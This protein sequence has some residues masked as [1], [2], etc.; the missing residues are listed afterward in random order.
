MVDADIF[1]HPAVHDLRQCG[2]NY[3]NVDAKRRMHWY[4]KTSTD[5][6][7]GTSLYNRQLRCRWLDS[8]RCTCEM[9]RPRT[10]FGTKERSWG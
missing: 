2:L 1:F 4:L 6:W 7:K 10:P 5:A 8:G 3:I 9:T